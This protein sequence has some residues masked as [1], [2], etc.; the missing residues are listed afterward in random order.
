MYAKEAEMVFTFATAALKEMRQCFHE[1]FVFTLEE[2][3][4][5]FLI[6]HFFLFH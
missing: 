1:A 4:F 6:F 3:K 5:F 2:V